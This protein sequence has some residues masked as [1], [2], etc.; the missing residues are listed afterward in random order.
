MISPETRA[1]FAKETQQIKDMG[2]KYEFADYPA[3]D[4]GG[5]DYTGVTLSRTGFGR[6]SDKFTHEEGWG[7]CPG[8]FSRVRHNLLILVSKTFRII[9]PEMHRWHGRD[10]WGPKFSPFPSGVKG[11]TGI[12]TREGCELAWA[13]LQYLGVTTDE[14]YEIAEILDAP[15]VFYLAPAD[16]PPATDQF[17]LFNAIRRGFQSK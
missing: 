15:R 10:K 1:H 6:L 2:F 17:P 7:V 16:P 9:T 13:Q 4:D 14:F 8:T 12:H 3:I 5:C 11:F